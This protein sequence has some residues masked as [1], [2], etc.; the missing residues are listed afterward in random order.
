ME[1]ETP[2]EDDLIQGLRDIIAN[3]PVAIQH[4][5]TKDYKGT[6]SNPWFACFGSR[7]SAIGGRL[8]RIETAG[9]M[10]TEELAKIK[11]KF[12]VLIEKQ[13]EAI[14]EHGWDPPKEIRDQFLQDL[15]DIY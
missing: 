1:N 2:R 3:S 14:N 4:E 11:G 15:D 10:S 8:A 13:S 6:Q 5:Y 7:I 12:Q 9:Q